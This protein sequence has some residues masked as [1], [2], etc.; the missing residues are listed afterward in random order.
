MRRQLDLGQIA[1]ADYAAQEAALAQAEQT[2]PPLQKQLA[3]ERDLIAYLT[4]RAPS[5][6]LADRLDLASLTLPGE[7]PLSLP[8][9]LVEQRPDVRAAEANLHSASA[10]VGV[11]IANRLPNF[12]L[13]ANAGGA[14]TNFGTLLSNSNTFWGL[15]AD[16]TQPIFEG[17][18]L[19]HKQR[20]AE[21]AF[22]QA[23]AQY[24][25][26]ALASFQ[27]VAD[28]LQALYADAATLRAAVDSERSAARSL[29]IAKRQLE[30]GQVAGV[31]VLVAEQAYQ[32]A[33]IAR[34]QAQAGRYADTVALY[35][36][37]GGGWWNRKDT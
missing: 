36:A 20:G 32:Q 15:A 8:S 14:S 11:A 35:Q 3:Q 29:A 24:R 22:D 2:L 17:G 19:L 34:I 26:A 7:L 9:K 28:V 31:A 10:Q 5:E 16:V 30:L 25:G 23:K 6:A 37:L 21:A 18:A 12:A 27:N 33:A 13:S 4:G 1:G